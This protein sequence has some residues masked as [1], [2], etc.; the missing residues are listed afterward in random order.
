MMSS[1]ASPPTTSTQGLKKELA[2]EVRLQGVLLGAML[3]TMWLEELVD[4]FVFHNQLNHYGIRPRELRGLLGIATGPFLHGSFA[5]LAANSVPL[6]V[7][8]LFVMAR[9]KRD[10][11]Y[12]FVGSALV[13]GLGTWLVG[14]S[15]TVHLGASSVVFGFLGYL[16]ALGW[17]ERS[18]WTVV[19]SVVVFL[20]Y[21]GALWGVL[22]GVPGISW[23]GH[24]FGL[25]GGVV[26]AR[27][28]ARRAPVRRV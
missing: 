1:M 16:L 11:G 14:R 24:L 2:R 20:L 5:H 8:G 13:A 17:F 21:G 12:V 10:L 23:E 9:R 7:L 25:L 28:L 22:P 19:G 4:Q 15:G 3:G 6:L 27:L 26:V 18:F